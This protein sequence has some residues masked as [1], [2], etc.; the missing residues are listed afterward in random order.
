MNLQ[1]ENLRS[2]A[3]VPLRQDESATVPGWLVE[4]KTAEWLRKLNPDDVLDAL[5]ND[6][7]FNALLMQAD[8]TLLG[9]HVLKVRRQYAK[10]LAER[11]LFA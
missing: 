5:V 3:A 1:I 4:M 7:R 9:L 2:T 6:E 10:D 11:E 8:A